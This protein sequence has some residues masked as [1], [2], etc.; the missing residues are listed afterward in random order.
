VDESQAGRKNFAVIKFQV[1]SLDW[2]FLS[3]QGHRRA[4]FHYNG[5]GF[6]ANWTNP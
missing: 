3:S 5:D 6:E 4:R 1:E 2:L